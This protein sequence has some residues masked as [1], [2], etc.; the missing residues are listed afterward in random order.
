MLHQFTFDGRHFTVDPLSASIH[1]TDALAQAAIEG[2]SVRGRTGAIA[3]ITGAFPEVPAEEA[4][5]LADEIEE[6]IADGKLFTKEAVR[7]ADSK[8]S[9]AIKAL[10]LHAAHS[11]NMACEYCFAAQGKYHGDD[12][13]MSAEN[14]KKAIDFLVKNSGTRRNL[15]VDFFGGEPLLNFG[16]VREIV[17]YARGLESAANKRFRF[18]LTTN[19]L[20]LTDEVTRFCNDEISNVVLSLDGRRETHDRFRKT[21]DG[22]GTYDIVVPKFLRFAELRKTGKFTSY[23]V[24]GTYTAANLDFT[25]DVFHVAD[26]GFASVAFEPAVGAADSPLAIK[27]E[28]LPQ[29]YEQYGRLAKEIAARR[30]TEREFHFYHFD[31]DFEN[32]PCIYKRTSGCGSG[33]EYFAV[34]PNLT[35]YPCHQLVGN[36]KYIA[37]TV[38]DGVSPGFSFHR[39]SIFDLPQC[40]DCWAALFCAGGCAANA[41][42]V[43]GGL[44]GED[45]VGCELFRRRLECAIWLNANAES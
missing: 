44:D 42:N 29:L 45:A 19:G 14:G 18:T 39:G 22:G 28:H 36:E 15:E 2:F 21:P 4:E 31:I 6:L 9:P 41:V 38:A 5:S 17:R 11:C 34:T 20:L 13:L 32:G 24:R 40:R 37:G 16:A 43:A 35:L 3:A 12:A 23:Y 30:G 1:E 8:L 26:L 27:A 25:E 7:P 33:S 10:C